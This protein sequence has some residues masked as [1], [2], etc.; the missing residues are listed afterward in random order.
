MK[1]YT[2]YKLLLRRSGECV[3][4]GVTTLPLEK[5]LYQHRHA[6]TPVGEWMRANKH[7]VVEVEEHDN[8]YTAQEHEMRLIAELKPKLNVRCSSSI[9][10][11]AG[12][13]K[14]GA[15]NK[16]P[17]RT[18]YIYVRLTEDLKDW[19]LGQPGKSDS[20]KVVSVL[21]DCRQYHQPREG[22]AS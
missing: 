15:K 6:D 5:R 3:Y 11:H 4:V 19:V 9:A 21:E 12:G 17:A 16:R 10:T 2:V 7:I 20:D 13:R 8:S 14:R 1:T 22:K 18:A